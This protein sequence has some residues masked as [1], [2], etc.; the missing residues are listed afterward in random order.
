MNIAVFGLGEA[1]SLIAYDLVKADQ[2]VTAFARR[3]G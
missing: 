3:L 1:G 2:K